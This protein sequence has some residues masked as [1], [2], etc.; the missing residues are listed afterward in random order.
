[1]MSLFSTADSAV[2]AK[3]FDK[4]PNFINK[5]YFY[6]QF[7][8]LQVSMHRVGIRWRLEDISSTAQI[9]PRMSHCIQRCNHQHHRNDHRPHSQQLALI[10]FRRRS[11]R[12]KGRDVLCDLTCVCGRA[13]F[14]INDAVVNVT[15]HRYSVPRKILVKVLAFA[16]ALASRRI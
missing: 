2:F 12:Q 7:L 10:V 15:R 13:I 5:F 14:V 1:M 3:F 8:L 16:N 4:T 9:A 6:K 11:P